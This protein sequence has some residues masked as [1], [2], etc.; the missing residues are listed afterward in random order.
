MMGATVMGKSGCFDLPM[1]VC[2][3]DTA[4]VAANSAAP[5]TVAPAFQIIS[6]SRR[7]QAADDAVGV[8]VSQL[9]GVLA[10][11]LE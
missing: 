6:Q 4:I 9:Q 5:M 11:D 7:G 1:A 2:G 8:L 10:D 3:R